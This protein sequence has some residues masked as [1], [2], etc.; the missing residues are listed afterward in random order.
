MANIDTK[1]FRNFTYGLF[2][3]TARE[4]EKDNGCIINTGIQVSD[5]RISIAVNKAGYTHDMIMRTKKF[6]LCF[7]SEEAPF[8]VFEHF[9][10]QSGRDVMK[11]DSC[12]TE[13]RTENG[14]LYLPKFINAVMSGEVI[15]TI[16]SDTHTIFLADVTE[17]FVCSDVKSMSYSYYF[18][19]VKPKPAPKQTEK[20]AWVCTVCGYI[21]EG[22]ELPA[23]F[24]CPICH[25]GAADFE[26]LH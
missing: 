22:D 3:L 23:D 19:H 14:L 8:L 17:S 7:L 4:D 20:K 13:N 25:H 9:G 10:M 21:Y 12:E 2:V 16:D 1:A 6:N 11:F 18:E 15:Q 26:P 24:I 5:G